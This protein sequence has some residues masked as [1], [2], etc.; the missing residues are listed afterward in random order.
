MQSENSNEDDGVD[1]EWVKVE[2][3][4]KYPGME[5]IK[6]VLGDK[7]NYYILA[8]ILA[9]GGGLIAL[10]LECFNYFTGNL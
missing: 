1:V 7:K 4:V 6:K 3:V 8:A 9:A 10:V 5:A 2:Q